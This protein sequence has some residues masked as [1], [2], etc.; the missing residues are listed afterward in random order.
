MPQ[1]NRLPEQLDCVDSGTLG[2]PVAGVV[3]SV[4]LAKLAGRLTDI[5]PMKSVKSIQLL[6]MY[7]FKGAH[8]AM[9]QTARVLQVSLLQQGSFAEATMNQVLRLT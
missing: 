9:R 5:I 7:R 2:C 4:P 1:P 6:L 8:A 3:H